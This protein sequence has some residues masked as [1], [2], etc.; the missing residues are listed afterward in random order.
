VKPSL[1]VVLL[2]LS[3][4]AAACGNGGGGG[5][6][7]ATEAQL[8]QGKALYEANCASCHGL[9]GEGQPNWKTP[10]ANGVYPAPP[11]DSTGHTWHHPDEVLLQVMAQGTGMP[12]S[13]MPTFQGVLTREEMEAILAYIKT[14]WGE[15]ERAFQKQVTDQW[16]EQN[17]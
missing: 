17:R 5:E 14:F 7:Q 16:K 3:L 6:A 9:A 11:H 8:A 2:F 4:L 13:G 1:L 12:K 15:E 10:D